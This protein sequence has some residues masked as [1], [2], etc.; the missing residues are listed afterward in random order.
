MDVRCCDAIRSTCAAWPSTPACRRRI[1]GPCA[2]ACRPPPRAVEARLLYRKFSAAYARA[3]C[4]PL[5][6]DERRRCLDVPVLEIARAELNLAAPAADSFARLVDHGLAL[7]EGVADRAADALPIL[8]R[9]HA[10][11]PDDPVPL[12]GRLRVY[13]KLGRTD[14]LANAVDHP[15]SLFLQTNAL[16][17]AY[18]PARATAE[19]LAARL[20]NDLTS[21][22]LLARAARGLDGDAAGA[23]DAADRV[24]AIDPDS[25]EA[26]FQ[27]HLALAELG[28]AAESESA[29][30]SWLHHRPSLETDQELRRRWRDAHAGPDE[31]LPLHVHDLK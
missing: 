7:A 6:G 4:A 10:L 26:H 1:P 12:L 30:K 14:E 23:L 27:R 24:L 2:F 20:P 11:Q 3:A 9:A 29:R 25:A 28:R 5:A 31:S 18:R 19:K 8:E 15:A 17:R 21:L 22:V 13:Y 16:L